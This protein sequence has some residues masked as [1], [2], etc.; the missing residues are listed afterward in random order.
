ML[1]IS[2]LVLLIPLVNI[3]TIQ[4][5][6]FELGVL[7]H[8]LKLGDHVQ[9]LLLIPPT[10]IHKQINKLLFPLKSSKKAIGFSTISGGIEVN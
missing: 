4:E 6:Q 2:P 1:K 3:Q 10:G 9:I 8:G 7:F 5:L